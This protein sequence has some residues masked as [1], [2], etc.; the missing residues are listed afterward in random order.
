MLDLGTYPVAF[1]TLVLGRPD[2]HSLERPEGRAVTS[3]QDR[4]LPAHLCQTAAE[5]GHEAHLREA[6]AQRYRRCFG[7]G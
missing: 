3:W 2:R 5:G 4:A 1:A 7:H 6:S